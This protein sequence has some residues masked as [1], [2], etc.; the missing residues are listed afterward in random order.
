M[1]GRFSVVLKPTVIVYVENGNKVNF[2]YSI[3]ALL[4]MQ[5]NGKQQKQKSLGKIIADIVSHHGT[6]QA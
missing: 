4:I 1:R 6:A 5:Q 2:F 3:F